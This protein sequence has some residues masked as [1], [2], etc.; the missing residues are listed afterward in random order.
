MVIL[1]KLIAL[2]QA[3]L[4]LYCPRWSLTMREALLLKMTL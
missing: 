1:P 4:D 2:K 3:T